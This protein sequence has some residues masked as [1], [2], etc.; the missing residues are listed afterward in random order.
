[1]TWISRRVRRPSKP[2]DMFEEVLL[3]RSF[4]YSQWIKSGYYAK[5]ENWMPW[6]ED[7]YLR[8]F[9]NDNKASY[10][11]KGTRSSELGRV[12]AFLDADVN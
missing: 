9:S 5:K 6:I 8:W 2:A 7:Q 3:T 11:T 10:A 1:M 4:F 12:C